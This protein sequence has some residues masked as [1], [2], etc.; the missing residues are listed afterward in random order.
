MA[1]SAAAVPTHAQKLHP[2][3]QALAVIVSLP[4]HAHSL[5]HDPHIPLTTRNSTLSSPHAVTNPPP[6]LTPHMIFFAVFF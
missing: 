5:A 2:C 4:T 1:V 6:P 3:S